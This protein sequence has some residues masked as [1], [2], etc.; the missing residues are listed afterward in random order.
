M[1]GDVSGKGA[2][3]AAVTAL[4]RYTLRTLASARRP[5]RTLRELNGLAATDVERHC[6]LVYAIA[7]PHE[8]G[9]S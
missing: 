7:R 2:E 4:A 1:L 8:A 3:A 6:T 9:P 5:S